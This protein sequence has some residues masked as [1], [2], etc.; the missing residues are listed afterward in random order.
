MIERFDIVHFPIGNVD[1]TGDVAAQIDQ[2]MELDSRLVSAEFRPRE[3]GQ[4]KI[5]SRGIEDVDGLIQLDREPI[6]RIEFARLGDEDVREIGIDAPVAIPI[7]LGQSIACDGAT[8]AEMIEFGFDG[9]QTDFDIT[10][11]VSVS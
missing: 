3:E 9:I 2:R 10:K 11:A 1:K 8:K 4:T 6:V 7:G 5:D